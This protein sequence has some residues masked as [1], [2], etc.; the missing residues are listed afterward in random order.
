MLEEKK[1]ATD[2]GV[3]NDAVAPQRPPMG[4]DGAA[5]WDE[6]SNQFE[7]PQSVL[8]PHAA[9]AAEGDVLLI[10]PKDYSDRFTRTMRPPTPPA[11]H[12]SVR[13]PA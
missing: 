11:N 9:A 2:I 5:G 3:G 4:G 7:V 8:A 13:Q 12:W 10:E 1:T 6:G